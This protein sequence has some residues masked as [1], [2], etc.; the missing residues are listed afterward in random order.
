MAAS[1]PNNNQDNSWV[2]KMFI[3][4]IVMCLMVVA[5]LA[6]LVSCGTPGHL[7]TSQTNIKDSTVVN[8][9]DSVVIRDS[10]VLVPMPVES[11]QNLLPEYV[12]SHLE[13]SV[14][15]S[16]AWVD[17]L[18]LH[19][20]LKNKDKPIEV[21]VPVTE[22]IVTTDTTQSQETATNN[23]EYV[24]VEKELSWWQKFR[25]G[26]FWW[27]CGGIALLSLILVFAFRKR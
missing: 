26:A 3:F 1:N 19:H 22:H 10:L 20:T 2:G 6:M 23:T 4:V 12:P 8:V 21:H 14:A 5:C 18:G 24:E 25:I 7:P 13:S 17:S 11:S 15:E 16:D 9:R 27:L